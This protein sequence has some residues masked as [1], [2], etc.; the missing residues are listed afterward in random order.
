MILRILNFCAKNPTLRKADFEF[1]GNK[2]EQYR[3]VGNAV[4]PKF[5]K[6]IAETILEI[7]ENEKEDLTIKTGLFNNEIT[8][9]I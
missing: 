3:Q 4:P 2:T 1:L 9:S 7:L 8:N 5:A 6:I